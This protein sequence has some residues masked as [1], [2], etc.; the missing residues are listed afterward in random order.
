MLYDAIVCLTYILAIY[1]LFI[2]L[3][4][5]AGSM[6]CRVKGRRPEVRVILLVRDSEE[7]IEYIVRNAAKNEIAAKLLSDAKIAVVDAG[8]SDSTYSLLERLQKT[9]PGI[10]VL[11]ISE[12]DKIVDDFTS[13]CR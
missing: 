7:H 1:G 6:R 5:I 3:S 12:L 13:G 8:S 10:E 11:K 2:L 9:Y 4:G